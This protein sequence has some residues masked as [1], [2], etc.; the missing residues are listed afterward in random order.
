MLNCSFV[1]VVLLLALGWKGRW[2]DWGGRFIGFE[3]M[4]SGVFWVFGKQGD[5]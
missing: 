4:N 1:A 5:E 3:R 2:G